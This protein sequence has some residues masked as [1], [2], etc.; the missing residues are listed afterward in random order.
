MSNY[1]SFTDNMHLQCNTPMAPLRAQASETAELESQI[2]FGEKVI[3]LETG[4]KDWIRIRNEDD[5]YEGWTDRK[6]F[7]EFVENK[8]FLSIDLISPVRTSDGLK[9]L[10]FGS[11]IGESDS[12][13][14]GSE[15]Y[16]SEEYDVE[17]VLNFTRRFENAPYL[18]GGKTI[19][20]IDCSGYMQLIHKP[21][22]INL[23]RN[24][25]QQALIGQEIIFEVRRAGDVAFFENENGKVVHVGILSDPDHIWHA[26]GCVRNDKFNSEGILNRDTGLISHKLF[27]LR[28]IG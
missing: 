22:G 3:I 18:W 5:A 2:L 15:G 27:N 13:M 26:S 24:A 20:G 9:F 25:S 19:L 23:P 16:T 14:D 1:L 7:I 6:H 10:P 4:N 17:K 8:S 28:R 11:K 12:L 21:F